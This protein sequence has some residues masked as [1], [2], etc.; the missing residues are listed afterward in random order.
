MLLTD[1]LSRRWPNENCLQTSAPGTQPAAAHILDEVALVA[2]TEREKVYDDIDVLDAYIHFNP[3][4]ARMLAYAQE[5]RALADRCLSDPFDFDALSKVTEAARTLG[6][7]TRK[8]T[9]A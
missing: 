4:G 5:H 1:L 6:I 2:T 3:F 7:Y 8:F 9:A